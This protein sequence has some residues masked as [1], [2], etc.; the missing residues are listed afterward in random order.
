MTLGKQT[1][2]ASVNQ[3]QLVISALGIEGTARGAATLV[4]RAALDDLTLFPL[5]QTPNVKEA[6]S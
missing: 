3:S 6:T 5:L 2:S 1:P 4:L